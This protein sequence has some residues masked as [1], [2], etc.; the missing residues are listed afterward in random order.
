MIQNLLRLCSHGQNF[1]RVVV[2]VPGCELSVHLNNF[3]LR[4]VTWP[5]EADSATSSVFNLLS[6]YS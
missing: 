2:A 1:F 5:H 4:T 6:I 3:I